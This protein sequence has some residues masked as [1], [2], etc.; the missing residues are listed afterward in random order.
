VFFTICN[1]LADKTR[2]L[3]PLGKK[4][5][6]WLWEEWLEAFKDILQRVPEWPPPMREINY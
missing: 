2:A 5:I 4:D 6:P 3:E 1:E